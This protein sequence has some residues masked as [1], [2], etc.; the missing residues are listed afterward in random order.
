MEGG[1]LGRQRYCFMMVCVCV[2]VCVFIAGQIGAHPRRMLGLWMV[3][4]VVC[5]VRDAVSIIS[6]WYSIKKQQ[7]AV[8]YVWVLRTRYKKRQWRPERFLATAISW[9]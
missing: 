9:L 3:L 7:G 6:E 1:G 8:G 2:C 5:A 4:F